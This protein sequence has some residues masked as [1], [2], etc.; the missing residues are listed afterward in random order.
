MQLS[1]GPEEL[2]VQGKWVDKRFAT[3]VNDVVVDGYTNFDFDARFS[4]AGAGLERTYLQLN[5]INLLDERYFGSISSFINAGNICPAGG[6]CTANGSNPS[7][8]L[9]APR[10]FLASINVGF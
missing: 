9:G 6:T 5:V 1:L 4:L 10:T 3:D 7:F 8:T 2:G